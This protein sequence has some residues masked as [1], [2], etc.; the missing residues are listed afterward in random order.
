MELPSFLPADPLANNPLNYAVPIFIGMIL[1]EIV[2]SYFHDKEN[3]YG[4]D[5]AASVSMGVGAGLL[6]LITKAVSLAAF[7]AVFELF[8]P[9]RLELLG[10]ETLGWAWYTWFICQ[11]FDDFN[12]YWHHRFSHTVRVLW[13]AHIVHHSSHHFNLGS[14]VRNGWVTLFYK[15]FWWLWMP[16]VGFEPIM[17]AICLGIQA[18]YQFNLHTK[19]VPKLGFLEKFMNTPTQHQVHHSANYAYLD[20]NH[21]GFLN[22][23]DRMFGTYKELDEE[24][25][26]QF[27]VLKPPNSFNPLII[28]SH[29]FRN[30]WEDV[31][32]AKNPKEVFMYIFGPPG[33]SPDGSTLTVRQIHRLMAAGL[34]LPGESTDKVV[35]LTK[36]R[37]DEKPRPTRAAV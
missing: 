18:I 22:I 25:E 35:Q 20:K 14:A 6:S 13:A 32:N 19:F 34:P 24:I 21:G 12:Y 37:K 23:F 3:F 2:L 9:I 5:L 7:Y 30:I 8:K 17:I 33:W 1:L 31:K 4:K 27:G 10:Y 11:F 15:P 36:E 29:E 16:M 28:V 26:P